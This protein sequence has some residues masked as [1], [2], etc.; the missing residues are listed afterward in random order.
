M[1]LFISFHVLSAFLRLAKISINKYS[2]CRLSLTTN[3]TKML[4]KVIDR[5]KICKFAY[6]AQILL[7]GVDS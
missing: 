3:G 6:M 7:Y 2:I 4:A 1:H 5:F